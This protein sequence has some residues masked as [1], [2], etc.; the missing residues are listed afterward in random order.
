MASCS[1]KRITHVANLEALT[2]LCAKHV[3]TKA[4][5]H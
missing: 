5:I 3:Y 4:A 2:T 1:S